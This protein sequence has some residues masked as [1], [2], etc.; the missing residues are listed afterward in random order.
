MII[1]DLLGGLGNQLFQYAAGIHLSRLH[2][3]PFK[4]NTFN[5][6]TYKLHK[7]SLEYFNISAEIAT[8]EEVRLYSKFSTK[9]FETITRKPYYQRKVFKERIFQYDENFKRASNNIMLVG[10][11]QSEKYFCE[12]ESIIR[13]EF[14]VKSLVDGLNE[15]LA[16]EIKRENSIS[17]HIRRG[18][19]ASD[20][21]TNKIHGVCDIQYYNNCIDKIVNLVKNPVFYIFSDDPS[22]VKSNFKLNYPSVYIDHNDAEKNYEDLRLMSYCKHNIIANSSFSWWG[23]WLNSSPDK[24]VLAPK[25]WFND[26]SKNSKDIIP[27]KWERV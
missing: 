1:A 20:L 26:W 21:K 2:Q 25:Q 6:E 13:T 24:H 22:W 17:L 4:I 12:I 11:W 5:F 18:D 9:I 7:Y 15:R 14:I 23:A 8:H 3:V 27:D 10:Y 19:Y 16:N